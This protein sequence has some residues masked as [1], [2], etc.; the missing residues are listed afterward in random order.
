MKTKEEL[1][2]L[3]KEVEAVSKGIHALSD[4]ELENVK[5]GVNWIKY[6]QNILANG[7]ENIPALAPLVEAI[8]NQ[9]WSLVAL[10]T[11]SGNIKTIPIVIKSLNAAE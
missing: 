6:G 5:G 9:N 7:G 11:L 1:S 10:I 8:R 3:K 4:D 2:T